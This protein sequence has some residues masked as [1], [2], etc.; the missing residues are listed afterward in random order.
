MRQECHRVTDQILH[1]CLI[2][3][4]WESSVESQGYQSLGSRRP[5]A[6][7]SGHQVVNI[8]SLVPGFSHLQNNSGNVYQI[9]LS[10]YHREEQKQR[11]RGERCPG[12]TQGNYTSTR[13]R[14]LNIYWKDWCWNWSSYI[15]VISCKQPTHWK[16]PWCWQRIRAGEGGN[17]GWDGWMA[18]CTQ[19]TWVWMNPERQWRREKPGMPQ[20][21]GSQRVRHDL[22]TEQKAKA[23]D[24]TPHQRVFWPQMSSTEIANPA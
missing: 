20:S 12:E 23:Q 16:R 2:G 7:C 17:D 11:I 10:R 3:W 19:W 15:L 9:L 21:M 8:F 18:L 1:N 13:H 22:V 6:V 4:W 14:T 5:G 24:G